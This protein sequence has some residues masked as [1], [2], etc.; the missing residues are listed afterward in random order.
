[1]SLIEPS[2][3]TGEFDHGEEVS[4]GLVIAAGDGA[5]AFDV[6]KEAL[7]TITFP[8]ETTVESSA[9]SLSCRVTADD[10][11]HGAPSNLPREIVRVVARVADEGAPLS[12]REQLVGGDHIVTISLRQRDVERPPLE[13][14]DR[15]DLRRESSSTTTQTI[16]D[17]PPFPPAAS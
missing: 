13:V 3:S 6:V 16:D 12:V 15:V 5:E 11:L 14:G 9:I 1:M 8:I 7:D 17:D 4:R 10:D 2:P